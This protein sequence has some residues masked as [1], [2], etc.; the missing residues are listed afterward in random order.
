MSCHHYRVLKRIGGDMD[1]DPGGDVLSFDPKIN[2]KPLYEPKVPII[3][4]SFIV[5]TKF[6][7]N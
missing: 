6:T 2:G 5:N 1:G 4:T 7:I 3:S